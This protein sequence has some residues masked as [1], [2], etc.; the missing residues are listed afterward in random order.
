MNHIQYRLSLIRR[1]ELLWQAADRRRA[2]EGALA[3]DASSS[4]RSRREPLK[5]RPLRLRRSARHS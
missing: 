5:L 3:A 2:N 1:D 4:I